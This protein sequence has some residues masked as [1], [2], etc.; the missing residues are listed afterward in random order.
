MIQ[1]EPAAVMAKIIEAAL[2]RA[3]PAPPTS[4]NLFEP[5]RGTAIDG[6]YRRGRAK[7]GLLAAAALGVA[8]WA[9]WQSKRPRPARVDRRRL[10][11]TR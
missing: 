1:S 4:G 3:E 2:A 10:E 9:W 8:G 7:V 11:P 6:G 5:S